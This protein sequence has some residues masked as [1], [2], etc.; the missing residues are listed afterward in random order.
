MDKH[1]EFYWDREKFQREI[2]LRQ[3]EITLQRNTLQNEKRRMWAV[4]IAVPLVTLAVTTIPSALNSASERSLLQRSAA[5]QAEMLVQN[6]QT[7]LISGALYGASPS[8]AAHRLDF[9]LRAGLLIDPYGNLDNFVREQL[10]N[11][12]PAPPPT[13]DSNSSGAESQNIPRTPA[14]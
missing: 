12:T 4:G 13:G 7:E 11:P 2:A 3:Q 8:E 10:S 14:N 5:I 9:L 6:R 1:S